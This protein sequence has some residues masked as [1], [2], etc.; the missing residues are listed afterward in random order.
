[1]FYIAYYVE[2]TLLLKLGVPLHVEA[3]LLRASGGIGEG[4]GGAGDDLY[5]DALAVLDMDSSAA[6]NRSG[7]GQRQTVQLDGG[8]VR[9]RHVE[10][11]VG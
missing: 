11:A 6:I 2:C 9:P 3:A 5:V 4:V 1:M 7:V 8:L 10:F